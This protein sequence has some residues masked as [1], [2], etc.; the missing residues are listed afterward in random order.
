MTL[1]LSSISLCEKRDSETKIIPEQSEGYKPVPH[2]ISPGCCMQ[3]LGCQTLGRFSACR[4]QPRDVPV[5]RQAVVS[6]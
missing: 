3:A 1:L 6:T 4:V 2:A 5:L